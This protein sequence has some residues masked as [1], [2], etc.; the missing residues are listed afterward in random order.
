M[1]KAKSDFI[2]TRNHLKYSSLHIHSDCSTCFGASNS[3]FKLA[4]QD[5]SCLMLSK[6]VQS[7]A[8]LIVLV[9][10]N[11][12]RACGIRLFQALHKSDKDA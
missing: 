10:F 5:L 7:E 1:G 8:Y 6:E 3:Q 12:T 2:A 11:Q 4:N 9:K